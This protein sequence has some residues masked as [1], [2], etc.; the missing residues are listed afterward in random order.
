MKMSIFHKM[1]AATILVL[2]AKNCEFQHLTMLRMTTLIRMQNGQLLPYAVRR[3]DF[4]PKDEDGVRRHV[5]F[6]QN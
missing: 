2:F 4:L 3:Y 6:H 5:E 1:A